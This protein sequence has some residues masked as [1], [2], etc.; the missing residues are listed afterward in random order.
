MIRDVCRITH[1]NDEAYAG[2]LAVVIAIRSILA[3]DW[4]PDKTFLATVAESIP[5]SAVRDR[6]MEL[7][8]LRI[9]PTEVASRFGASGW[10]VD[11][12][13]LAL[14]EDQYQLGAAQ[15][16]CYF[17]PVKGG[18]SDER[19]GTKIRSRRKITKA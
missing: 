8:S 9:S 1:H 19:S 4:A 16:P 11:T 7:R 3:G 5:D 17:L 12:V 6:A 15:S 2:A 13:L 18:S 10:V 14:Y